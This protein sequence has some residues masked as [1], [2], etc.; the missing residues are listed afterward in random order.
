VLSCCCKLHGT[1]R[2]KKREGMKGIEK[3]VDNER[4]PTVGR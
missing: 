1:E 2:N 3:D 4:A